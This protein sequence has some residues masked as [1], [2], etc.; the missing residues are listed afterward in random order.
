[1]QKGEAPPGATASST[2]SNDKHAI[3]PNL[4]LKERVAQIDKRV[5]EIDAELLEKQPSIGLGL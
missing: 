5:A 2:S 1:M 4:P 3:D